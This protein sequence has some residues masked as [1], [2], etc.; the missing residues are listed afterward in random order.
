MEQ[1]MEANATTILGPQYLVPEE[2][3]ASTRR[4]ESFPALVA[5]LSRQSVVKHFDAYADIAWDSEE[6]RIDPTDPRW[7]L[8]EDDVLGA[9]AWYRSQPQPRR[10][11]IGL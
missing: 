4:T 7:E 2:E 5:R 3:R 10:A 1:T 9:T 11:Q 6:F 8:T